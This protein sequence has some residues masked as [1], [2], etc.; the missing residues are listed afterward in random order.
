MR[1][2][3]RVRGVLG[4]ALVWGVTWSVLGV[5]L[6]LG[7]LLLTDNYPSL[8]IELLEQAGAA[9]RYGFAYGA[10]LGLG[11]ALY[12]ML[13][14]V[15]ARSLRDISLRQFAVRGAA[16]GIVMH[17][18]VVGAPLIDAYV[19]VSAALS[20]GVS[21]GSLMMARRAD[22]LSPPVSAPQLRAAQ[23]RLP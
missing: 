3:R 7:R 5:S 23:L 15:R 11:F 18:W 17:W 6:K 21:T 2:W 13:A 19:L 14:G 4:T 1:L 22:R 10:A 9:W 16:V 20:A 12:V 8:R